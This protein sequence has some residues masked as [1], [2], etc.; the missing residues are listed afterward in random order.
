MDVQRGKMQKR[1]YD[2]HEEIQIER[3]PGSGDEDP[4]P[5]AS[6]P[7]SMEREEAHRQDGQGDNTA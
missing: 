5:C 7:P 6:E 4:T 2:E 3:K 1:W